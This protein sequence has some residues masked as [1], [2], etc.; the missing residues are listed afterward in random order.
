MIN[1]KPFFGLYK[2]YQDQLIKL[3]DA[4]KSYGNSRQRLTEIMVMKEMPATRETHILNRG[5]YS[6]RGSRGRATPVVLPMP[7]DLPKPSGLAQ[8]LTSP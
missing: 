5:L 3:S 8:W 1:F 6:D 7:S 2:P 4:R